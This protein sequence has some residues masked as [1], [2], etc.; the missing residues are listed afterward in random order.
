[1]SLRYLCLSALLI[2]LLLSANGTE[3]QE[4]DPKYPH[5]NVATTYVVDPTWPQKPADFKWAEMPG[6]TVPEAILSIDS[7]SELQQLAGL[8]LSHRAL[9][10]LRPDFPC[11]AVCTTG[12]DSRFGHLRRYPALS[13]HN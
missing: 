2:G 6:V 4:K 7:L 12:P 13:A 5:V 8:G 11:K 3:A 1:M 9:L 10:R